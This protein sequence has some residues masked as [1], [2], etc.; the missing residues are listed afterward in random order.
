MQMPGR[1]YSQPN[2]GYRYGFNGKENDNEVKGQGNQQDY[3]MRIYDPRLG[4]F[5]S[6]DPITKEYPELTPYQFAGNTSIQAIDLDGLEPY[7]T[8]PQQVFYQGAADLT[9]GLAV[10]WD[11]VTGFFTSFKKESD[12]EFTKT[13][14]IVVTN[15]TTVNVG[16]NMESWVKAGRY[17]SNNKMPPLKFTNFFDIEVKNETKVELKTKE[18]A[19]N[20]K[21]ETK[22]N[23]LDGSIE[24]K[25]TIKVPKNNV[26]K[27]PLK[28]SISQGENNTTNKSKTKL[29]VKTDTKPFAVGGVIE[30][31]KDKNGSV[32]GK[33]GVTMTYETKVGKT[34]STST[35]TVGKKF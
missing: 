32:N 15:E 13:K 34:T 24:G 29:D 6:E 22:I 7:Y 4:R 5:L 2:S 10:A 1:T 8:N 19:G 16:G 14:S 20:I 11:K 27:V 18:E 30:L 9:Q 31:E 12:I 35:L 21:G 26:T 33:A 28:I 3:G 23:L 25:T 17:S